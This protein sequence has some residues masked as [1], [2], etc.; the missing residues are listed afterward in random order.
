MDHDHE[1]DV[2]PIS[3]IGPATMISISTAAAIFGIAYWLSGV[4]QVSKS[5]DDALERFRDKFKRTDEIIY[6][7]NEK[8][9]KILSELSERTARI[10]GMLQKNQ[11]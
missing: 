2:K 7:Q 11:K 3:Q 6:H 10:E 9:L 5:H 4:A 1:I 8:F